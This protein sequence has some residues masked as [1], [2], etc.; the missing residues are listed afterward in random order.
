MK[1]YK[2]EIIMDA[3]DKVDFIEAL[4]CLKD[5]EL[6]EHIVEVKE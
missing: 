1:T 5:R 3:S 4:W 6:V 2:I